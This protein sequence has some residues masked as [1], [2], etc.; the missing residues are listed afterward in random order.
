MVSRSRK[1]R[2]KG[3]E[4]RSSTHTAGP[5]NLES[6]V[7]RL[8]KHSAVGR[9]VHVHTDRVVCERAGRSSTGNVLEDGA[10]VV[11]PECSQT[12]RQSVCQPTFKVQVRKVDSLREIERGARLE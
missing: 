4:H 8:H 3:V 2:E 6:S 12:V 5:P 9:V 10:T 11:Y 7:T 1:E